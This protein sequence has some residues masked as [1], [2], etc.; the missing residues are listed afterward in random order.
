[1]V[2]CVRDSDGAGGLRSSGVSHQHQ[3]RDLTR[4][5]PSLDWGHGGVDWVDDDSTLSALREARRRHLSGGGRLGSR[6][7]ESLLLHFRVPER[8]WLLRLNWRSSLRRRS[9]ATRRRVVL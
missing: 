3:E 9:R 4:H 7:L 2:R 6:R 5:G 8:G 1:M